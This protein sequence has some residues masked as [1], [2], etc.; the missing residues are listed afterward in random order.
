MRIFLS[1]NDNVGEVTRD[2]HPPNEVRLQI[3]GW[4]VTRLDSIG[5]TN[6][7][8]VRRLETSDLPD[9]T[10]LVADVQTAG[11]GRLDRRWEAPAGEN[12]LCSMLFRPPIAHPQRLQHA[13]ALAIVAAAQHFEVGN[14][15]LKW[16][17]D[18]IVIESD[19]SPRAEYTKLAGMLS[20]MTADGAVIIGIG[21]NINWAPAGATSLAAIAGHPLSP[22]DVLR[23]LLSSLHDLL[24]C[25]ED[26][27]TD[28]YRNHLSTIG[29]HVRVE[30]PSSEA[31]IGRAVGVS[32]D[33]SL[34]VVD[35]CAITHRFHAGDVVHLR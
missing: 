24:V 34:E 33:G 20:T 17:N 31:V 7:E 28:R 15:S 26:E 19:T 13:V 8:L 35:E 9:R 29:R 4:H 30:L 11:R 25:S 32:P 27:L 10:V 1:T 2:N 22:I 6:D 23:A 16:P 21:V 18:V 12:L 14:V 5:S 3:E